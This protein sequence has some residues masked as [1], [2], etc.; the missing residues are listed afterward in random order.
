MKGLHV[1]LVAAFAIGAAGCSSDEPPA[2]ETANTPATTAPPQ[3]TSAPGP[4]VLPP[5]TL[6]DA[7]EPSAPPLASSPPATSPPTDTAPAATV[8][9]PE[10][11]TPVAGNEPK[12]EVECAAGATTAEKCTVDKET[13]V[14]WR[15]F[16]GQCQVCH[17]ASALGSTFAPN[18]LGRFHSRVDYPRFVDVV[19]HGYHGQVGVMPAWKGNPNVEPHIDAIFSYLKARADG[20]LPS[21][22]PNREKP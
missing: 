1:L 16:A 3:A 2:S 4:A 19:L 17:G 18:L 10:S 5:T 8:P 14:G 9:T 6:P 11:G 13:Y 15:T 20:V 21:G 22:R 12:Y 7:T